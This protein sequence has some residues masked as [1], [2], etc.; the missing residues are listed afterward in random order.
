[1]NI[2]QTL[3]VDPFLNVLVFLVQLTGS[4]G[5]AIILL[6]IALRLIM[7]PL[8]LP[9]L[10]LSKKMAELAPELASLKEK[11][12]DDKQGLVLAQTELYKK[13]GANP[14]AGCL[15]QV[16]QVVVLIAL[17]NALNLLLHTNSADI[18]QV[19]NSRLYDFNQLSQGFSLSTK[20]AYLDLLKPDTIQIPGLPIPLPGIFL[21]FSALTQFLSAKMM[22]PVVSTEK[23]L[24]EKTK[25][26]ADD[27]MVAMQQQMIIMFPLMTIVFGFQF[28]AGLVLYWL[29]FS[30]M[31]MIQQYNITGW[32]G[33]TPL[34]KRFNLLK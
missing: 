4:L 18:A 7:T 2:F 34:L 15:P 26:E 9:G 20:F 14:A 13:H 10:K 32:G 33:L 25:P 29:V 3:L 1:M 8:T 17:F 27:A 19:L 31:A 16:F 22:S 24:A 6:T 28:P 12:K 21:L 5:W 30:V 23:K 11:Y